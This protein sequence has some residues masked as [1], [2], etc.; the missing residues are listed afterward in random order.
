MFK[1]QQ[2]RTSFSQNSNLFTIESSVSKRHNYPDLFNASL[3]F[4]ITLTHPFCYGLSLLLNYLA[5]EP[6]PLLYYTPYHSGH[7]S[8]SYQ[9]QRS[10]SCY[11]AESFKIC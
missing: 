3:P 5:A 2:I 1:T 8:S 10:I 11:I 9:L 7:D 4:Y 6:L